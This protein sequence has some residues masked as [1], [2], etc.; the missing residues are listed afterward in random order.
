MNETGRPGWMVIHYQD[1]DRQRLAVIRAAIIVAREHGTRSNAPTICEVLSTKFGETMKLEEIGRMLKALG[2]GQVWNHAKRFYR[3]D[4]REL[5]AIERSITERM[6]R[7]TAEIRALTAGYLKLCQ[8]WD[9]VQREYTEKRARA[10]QVE[11]LLKA[12]QS[13]AEQSATVDI[14][15]L[16]R[17]VEQQRAQAKHA[18]ELKQECEEWEQG[19]AREPGSGARV[20]RSG[21]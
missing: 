8:Q 7:S 11:A 13:L 12:S 16:E 15:A 18:Q 3:L 20:R 21:Y 4:I 1:I 6:E 10:S 17:K 5:K 19:W 14:P 9:K 2:V